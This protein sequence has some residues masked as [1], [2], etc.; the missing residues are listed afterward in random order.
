M[1]PGLGF[2]IGFKPI[3]VHFLFIAAVSLAFSVIITMKSTSDII[4]YRML[5][6]CIMIG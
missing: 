1:W 5:N 6:I 3:A 2:R 4:L